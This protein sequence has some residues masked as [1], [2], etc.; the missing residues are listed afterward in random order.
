MAVG[1]LLLNKSC[2]SLLACRISSAKL[3]D[4]LMGVLLNVTGCFSLAALKILSVANLM[5]VFVWTYLGDLIW[6]SASWTWMCSLGKT[7]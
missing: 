1:L 6:D 5:N 7:H 4:S 2:H 3:A